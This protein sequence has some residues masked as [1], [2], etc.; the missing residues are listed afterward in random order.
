[1]IVMGKAKLNIHKI[2][3]RRQGFHMRNESDLK[4]RI[5]ELRREL[6][7]VSFLPEP[8]VGLHRS[9]LHELKELNKKLSECIAAF[10]QF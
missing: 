1:M 8:D 5:F 2:K 7:R 6:V 4:Q 3:T 10:K 9:L